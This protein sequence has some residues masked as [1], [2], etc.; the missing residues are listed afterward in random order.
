MSSLARASPSIPGVTA[1]WWKTLWKLSLP[2]KIKLFAWRVCKGWIPAL[3]NLSRKKSLIMTAARGV[4]VDRKRS[5]I[6]YGAAEGSVKFGSSLVS[7]TS[8]RIFGENTP[9]QYSSKSWRTSRLVTWNFL[10]FWFENCGTIG[11]TR[12]PV[13]PN[14]TRRTQWSGLEISLGTSGLPK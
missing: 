3:A 14:G 7:L 9:L 13:M 6:A 5:R 12:W 8:S 2:P 10:W 11:T 1:R 4:S